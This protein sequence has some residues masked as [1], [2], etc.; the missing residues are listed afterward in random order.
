MHL[1]PGVWSLQ[2]IEGT[3]QSVIRN[4]AFTLNLI[5]PFQILIQHLQRELLTDLLV[6]EDLTIGIRAGTLKAFE[7]N[8]IIAVA[9]VKRD[10]LRD[11]DKL[12]ALH[13]VFVESAIK[14]RSTQMKSS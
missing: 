6:R 1:M 14:N 5:F 11:G 9:S 7:E 4:E 2:P 12:P 3:G 10:L 13:K 8:T